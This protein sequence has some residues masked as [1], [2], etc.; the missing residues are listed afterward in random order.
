MTVSSIVLDTTDKVGIS[1]GTIIGAALLALLLLYCCFCRKKKQ[2]K[3]V[4]SDSGSTVDEEK[5]L[6]SVPPRVSKREHVATSS[7]VASVGAGGWLKFG[8]KKN[9][10][11]NTKSTKV[12]QASAKVQPNSVNSSSKQDIKLNVKKS[13]VSPK[14]KPASAKT[15]MRKPT[16]AVVN[17]H[18]QEKHQSSAIKNAGSPDAATMSWNFGK[19][20]TSANK[21]QVQKKKWFGKKVPEV[22][23]PV[24]PSPVPRVLVEPAHDEKKGFH[25]LFPRKKM[26][27]CGTEVILEPEQFM[28]KSEEGNNDNTTPD[29]GSMIEQADSA[30]QKKEA[31]QQKIEV[32]PVETRKVATPTKKEMVSSPDYIQPVDCTCCGL[33]P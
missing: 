16:S 13:Q 31:K 4:S 5:A 19:D 22:E 23:E 33:R 21:S 32:E 6:A 27:Q 10:T 28:M 26:D 2:D 30:R 18:I 8:R 1:M 3:D 15:I 17:S 14:V 20:K 25:S 9:A 12:V 29:S 24:T 11:L 7:G